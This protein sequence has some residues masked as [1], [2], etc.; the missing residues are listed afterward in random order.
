VAKSHP[1]AGDTHHRKVVNPY[2]SND[3]KAVA[4]YMAQ[5]SPPKR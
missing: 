1:R 3:L 4:D 2:P 5:I